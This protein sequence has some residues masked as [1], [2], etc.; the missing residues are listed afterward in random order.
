MRSQLGS[1]LRWFV[2]PEMGSRLPPQR[3]Q[4]NDEPETQENEIAKDVEEEEEEEE[5][6]L[7]V[8]KRSKHHANRQTRVPLEEL[9]ASSMEDSHDTMAFLGLDDDD[10]REAVEFVREERAGRGELLHMDPMNWGPVSGDIRA[11]DPVQVGTAEREDEVFLS[12]ENL[13]PRGGIW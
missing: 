6:V 12:W 11:T 1:I 9:E 7:F 4:V 8:A 10:G 3:D 2:E 5:V 13:E